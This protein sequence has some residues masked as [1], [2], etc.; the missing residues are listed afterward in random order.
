MVCELHDDV[1]LAVYEAP[2]PSPELELS[3]NWCG[4]LEWTRMTPVELL[5]TRLYAPQQLRCERCGGRLEALLMPGESYQEA[6]RVLEA[7]C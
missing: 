3:C 5:R 7:A 2:R 1:N 6:A 4:A